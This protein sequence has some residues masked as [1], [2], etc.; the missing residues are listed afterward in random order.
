MEKA[1]YAFQASSDAISFWTS[2]ETP[3]SDVNARTSPAM[4]A[5]YHAPRA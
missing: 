5:R 3:A 4:R 1:R 2:T